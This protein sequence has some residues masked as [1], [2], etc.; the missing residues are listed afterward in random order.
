MS[1]PRGFTII[2]MLISMGIFAVI[3][4]LVM[5]N[6]RV[7]SQGDELRSSSQLVASAIRRMQTA[8]LAGQ[9]THFCRDAEGH[10]GQVC[11]TGSDSECAGGACVNDTPRGG[12]GIHFE[13]FEPNDRAMVAFADTNGDGLYQ[14]GEEIRRDNVSPNIYVSVISVAPALPGPALDIVF[15]PPRPSVKFNN[16]ATADLVATIV[17]RHRST[18]LTKEV[19]VN[20]ISGRISAD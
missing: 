16:G 4:G 6:F 17:L 14:A 19:T 11:P 18:M 13:A 3:T 10:D 9:T 15:V 20:S 7:G 2:E 12:Y 5:A 8:A 1:R